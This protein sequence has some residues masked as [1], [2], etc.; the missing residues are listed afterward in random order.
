MYVPARPQVYQ[1]F[2]GGL[3][4][5]DQR[6]LRYLSKSGVKGNEEQLANKIVRDFT[7][8]QMEELRVGWGWGGGFTLPQMEELRVGGWGGRGAAEG[9]HTHTHTRAHTHTHTHTHARTH[10]RTHAHASAVKHMPAHAPGVTPPLPRRTPGLPLPPPPRSRTC[11]GTLYLRPGLG[12][13]RQ[14]RH[15][16]WQS[17]SG[18]RGRSTC[19]WVGACLGLCMCVCGCVAV[20]V[21][22]CARACACACVCVCVCVP[23]WLEGWLWALE[24]WR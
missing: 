15:E 20:C 5:L 4:P 24:G 23:A 21:C 1:V 9:A 6:L 11:H 7:L 2:R 8:P 13:A 16:S 18:L 19:R 10:A 12:G 17:G 14:T 3:P 22:V